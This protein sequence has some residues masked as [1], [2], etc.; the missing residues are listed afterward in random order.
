MALIFGDVPTGY[1]G[2]QGIMRWFGKDGDEYVECRVTGTALTK[3]FGAKGITDAELR[4]AF[5]EN[6]E[7]IEKIA[8][9]KYATGDVTIEHDSPSQTR[10]VVVID[11]AG[12]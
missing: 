10:T 12:S 8:K 3:D 5:K 11:Y 1:D 4:R 2:E 6:R 9:S 7:K